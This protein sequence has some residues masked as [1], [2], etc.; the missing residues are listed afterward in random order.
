MRVLLLALCWA[1]LPCIARAADSA[2]PPFEQA[3]AEA[4][5]AAPA[6]ARRW[7]RVMPPRAMQPSL[8]VNYRIRNW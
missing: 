5:S 8:R 1:V 4:E 3:L 7:V 2:S 6:L